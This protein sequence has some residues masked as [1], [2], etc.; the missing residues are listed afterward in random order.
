M[1]GIL[2]ESAEIAGKIQNQVIHGWRMTESDRHDIALELG[3][4]CWY[5][6]IASEMLGFKFSEIANMNL[7]KLADRKNRNKIHGSGDNR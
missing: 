7:Q 1:L 3:D 5:L 2:G 6:A 4:L